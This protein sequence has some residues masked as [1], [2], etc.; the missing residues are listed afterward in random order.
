MKSNNLKFIFSLLLLALARCLY[1]QIIGNGLPYQTIVR[2]TS[3]I[4]LTNQL[5][6][7]KSGIFLGSPTG[8]LKWEETFSGTTDSR[9]LIKFTIGTGVST[10]N[11][12]LSSFDQMNFAAGFYFLKISIDANGGSS[13]NDIG[14]AQLL[15]VPY[16]FYSLTT[17]RV[18]GY[19]LNQLADVN[20]SSPMNGRLLKW[21]G[22]FWIAA[23][24]LDSDTA[25]Y[26]YNTFHSIHSDTSFYSYSTTLFD[27]VQFSNFSNSTGYATVS[28]NSYNSSNSVYSDTAL[29]AYNSAP[30]AWKISGNGL[31]VSPSYY[32]GT[33][34]LND[35]IVK[36]NNTEAIRI[37]SLGRVQL[38]GLSGSSSFSVFGTEGVI[39]NGTYGSGLYAASS[40]STKLLWYPAKSSFRV[41]LASGTQW[42]DVNIGNYSFAA[43]YNCISGNNSFSSGNNCSASGDYAIAIGR[44][45]QATATGVYPSGVSVAIGDSSIASTPRSL[46][47]GRGNMASTN[48]AAYSIGYF[49][50]ST[51]AVSTSFGFNNIASGNYSFVL[52]CYAS[53]NSKTGSF[54]YAD[55]SSST[56]TNSTVNNQFLVK[57]SG[58]VVFYSDPANTM[59]VSL[60]SGGGSWASVSDRNK[61]ENIAFVDEELILKKIETIKIFSWN[62]KAQ[63]SS[64]KHIGPKA[65]E[66]YNLFKLGDDK[67]TI[68][69]I[70]MDG[71]ILSGIKALIKRTGNLQTLLEIDNIEKKADKI[72]DFDDLNNRLDEIEKKLQLQNFE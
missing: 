3:G 68:S 69:S 66:F 39:F 65:Q 51:G 24:D 53:S 31:G 2:N 57:A 14:S 4:E 13:Y 43:G 62:Y 27:S 64:I 18:T 32:L 37:N 7:I 49:N 6:S 60:P 52:G 25:A 9:G 16:S 45:S 19:Y 15:S 59:G 17:D 72:N 71:V 55:A 67:K 29:F 38:G 34:D 33:N 1:C 70:D 28:Q 50:K 12:T 40:M 11:G 54:V 35:F 23:V 21:N 36:T 8:T 22:F 61:K 26:A 42:D 20:V 5:V 10:G 48:N 58:G 47:L 41:G 44:K 46:V 56:I 63:D 30:T